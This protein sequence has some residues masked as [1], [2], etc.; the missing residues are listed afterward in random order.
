MTRPLAWL[1]GLALSAG[2][3][4]GTATAQPALSPPCRDASHACLEAIGRLYITALTTHDGSALPLAPDVRRTENALTSAR[5]ASEVR[6]SFARTTMIKR[7]R[8]IRPYCD[9]RRGEVIFFFVTDVMLT[10]AELGGGRGPDDKTAVTVPPG[11]YTI[12]EAER[13]RIAKGLITEIEILAHVEDG[14]GHGS[15]WPDA[16]AAIMDNP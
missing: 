1:A 7:I 2:L 14:L 11:T 10:S 5:G 4:G 6:E 16:R 12:H 9:A 8:D 3:I 15:G 13:F